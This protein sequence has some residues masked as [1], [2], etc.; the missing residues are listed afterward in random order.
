MQSLKLVAS[1]VNSGGGFT[2]DEHDHIFC[3]NSVII[4]C[5]NEN[6]IDPYV[7]LAI[8]NSKVFKIWTQHR[9]PTL[10]SGWYSY[11]VNIMRKFPIPISKSGQ[12]KELFCNIA[13]FA[14]RLLHGQLNKMDRVNI[15]SLIDRKVSELYGI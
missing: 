10:G 3:N 4:L 9:M 13:D 2:L 12:N 14:R 5:P 7:L 1:V 11:R 8:V 15:L 6:V